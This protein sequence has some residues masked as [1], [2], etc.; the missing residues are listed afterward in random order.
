MYVAKNGYPFSEDAEATRFGPGPVYANRTEGLPPFG[1][2][3]ACLPFNFAVAPS[4]SGSY[5]ITIAGEE[6]VLDAINYVV[7]ADTFVLSTDGN[8]NTT[9]GVKLTVSPL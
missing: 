7:E 1:T 3:Q 4:P 6:D 5:G 9:G 8:F 2:I